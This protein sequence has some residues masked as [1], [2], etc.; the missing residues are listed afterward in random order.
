MIDYNVTK[1]ILNDEVECSPG[2]YDKAVADAIKCIDLLINIAELVNDSE[3]MSSI[4]VEKIRTT[5]NKEIKGS[6]ERY[7][8]DWK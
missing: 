6:E 1:A 4:T 2:D 5:V 7:I 8:F 3:R